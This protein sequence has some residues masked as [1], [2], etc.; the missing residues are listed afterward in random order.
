VF[1]SRI[2]NSHFLQSQKEISSCY[3][4]RTGGVIVCLSWFVVSFVAV[5]A[6]TNPRIRLVNTVGSAT[7]GRVE[8]QYGGQ[9][10]SVCNS[11]NAA[12]VGNWVCGELGLGSFKNAANYGQQSPENAVV[13]FACTSGQTLDQCV[14]SGVSE[15][16]TDLGFACTAIECVVSAW[17]AWSTCS[18]SCGG[19]TELHTRTVE[20]APTPPFTCPSLV[21][22]QACNTQPCPINC[23]APNPVPNG[24]YFSCATGAANG[25]SCPLTCEVGYQKSGSDPTCSLGSYVGTPPT[26]VQCQVS[27]CLSYDCGCTCNACQQPYQLLDG[28]CVSA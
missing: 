6:Q 16:C 5:S 12:A 22:S 20:I 21:A 27:E 10:F 19:G 4:M 14:H 2:H 15:T 11:N 24:M 9:W 8:V 17:S 26:C 28:V 25:D 1:C 13:N 7:Q 3:I 18:L 23:T